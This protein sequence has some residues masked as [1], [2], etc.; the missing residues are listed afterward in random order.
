MS[1]NETFV[2]LATPMGESA[3]AMIRLSGPMA[4]LL[5]KSI[6]DI[7]ESLEPRVSKVGYYQTLDG[8]TLD[9]CAYIYFEAPRSFTGEDM[10]EIHPHGNPL[11]LRRILEDLG[12]RG[13][14]IAEPGE[15][16]RTAFQNKKIDL[17]QAEAIADLIRAK[18]DRALELAQKQLKGVFGDKINKTIYKLIQLMARIEA[19]I[20]FADE[21]LPAED[22]AEAKIQL[23]ELF[24]EIK[25][26]IKNYQVAPLL[27]DGIKTAI[28]GAPNAG[29]STLL[30]LLLGRDRAIV[31]AI[32]GTTR[33]FITELI[34]LGPYSLQLIDTAGLRETDCPIEQAGIERSMS[35]LEQADLCIWVI[36]QS[37]S[38]QEI[39]VVNDYQKKGKPI[40]ILLNK[41]DCGRH[42]SVTEERLNH[43]NN[44]ISLSLNELGSRKVLFLELLKWIDKELICPTE[45]DFLINSRHMES[46]RKA[47]M[48]LES[49]LDQ[50]QKGLSTEWIASDLRLAADYLGEITGRIEHEDVLDELFGSFCIGK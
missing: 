40:L 30:N 49:A 29:K 16:T 37:V 42:E 24:G 45:D 7:K 11:I 35:Q 14:R 26:W 43:N 44:V 2:G 36:D 38:W 46:F 5:T 48:V 33:D 27:R 17:T 28:I 25:H 32:P 12:L 6:F 9:N 3:I 39:D 23:E 41:A 13:C 20:D 50:A 21:D 18:S 4:P 8:K 19:Y 10:L 22:Y 15:F 1:W 34:A 31:S 47:Y